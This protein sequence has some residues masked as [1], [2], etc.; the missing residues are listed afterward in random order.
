[1]NDHEIR[2]QNI[3]D[4]EPVLNVLSG[5]NETYASQLLGEV[6]WKLLLVIKCLKVGNCLLSSYFTHYNLS[7]M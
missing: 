6:Y 5:L 2:P 1:M 3:W 4:G 7:V